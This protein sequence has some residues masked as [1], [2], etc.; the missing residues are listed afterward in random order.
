MLRLR[1]DV[2]TPSGGIPSP[3]YGVSATTARIIYPHST[4]ALVFTNSI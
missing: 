1:A 4:L 2:P 3:L